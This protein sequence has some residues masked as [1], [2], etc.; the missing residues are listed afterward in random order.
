MKVQFEPCRGLLLCKLEKADEDGKPKIILDPKLQAALDIKRT[1][2][3][4][5]V[6]SNPGNEY[7]VGDRVMFGASAEPRKAH[8]PTDEGMTEFLMVYDNDVV[9]RLT[10]DASV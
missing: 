10:K 6:A 7:Q 3:W 8:F 5:V 9:G 2:A 1:P 4:E